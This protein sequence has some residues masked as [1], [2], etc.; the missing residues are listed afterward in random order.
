MKLN[1]LF[2]SA[3]QDVTGCAT[4]DFETDADRLTAGELLAEL[5]GRWP[6][7]E[8]WSDRI[9]LAA[10]LEFIDRGTALRDGQE[11]AFMPPVQGG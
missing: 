7:L 9:L 5:A 10:D 2:F 6:G 3:L 1:V 4:L 11:I 8:A